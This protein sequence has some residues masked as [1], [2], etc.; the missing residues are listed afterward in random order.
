M[1]D[2]LKIQINNN[3]MHISM[4]PCIQAE[5]LNNLYEIKSIFLFF[6][7]DLPDEINFYILN[8]SSVLINLFHNDGSIAL[9]N[10][11][12]NTNVGSIRKIIQ[13]SGDL[14]P[15]NL[16]KIEN[17]IAVLNFHKLKLFF[18]IAKFDNKLINQNIHAGTLSFELSHNNEKIITNCGSIEKRFGKKPEY[19]RFSAAHSTIILNNTNISELIEKKSYKRAPKN[20]QFS[21]NEDNKNFYW[22]ASHDGYKNNFY[23]IIK[24]KIT[25]S[26]NNFKI[27]GED[28]I[29]STK[30]S[31][32]NILINIRFH[33]TPSCT[34]LLT[35]NKE[36]ILIKTKSNNSYIFRSDH[37]LSLDESISI[38]DGNKIEK[39][40]QIVISSYSL[41]PKVIRWSFSQVIK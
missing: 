34:S 17:G 32:N 15:K 5:I 1:K 9:F 41:N 35:N 37:K 10:G 4:N 18:D 2:Y 12:N 30:L 23:K 38:L 14:K 22:K 25:I 19:L 21:S 6:K 29:L 26:K 20:I 28:T 33:L 31:K 7:L 40:K 3:G 16:F 8:M 27:T 39:T 24:R 36:T 11:A 13:L